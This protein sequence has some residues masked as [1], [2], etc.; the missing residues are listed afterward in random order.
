L[1]GS[2]SFLGPH[3]LYL[4]KFD[5]PVAQ[6]RLAKGFELG[7]NRPDFLRGMV[8]RFVVLPG[9]NFDEISLARFVH[10][11]QYQMRRFRDQAEAAIRGPGLACTLAKSASLPA[12][13]RNVEI[14]VSVPPEGAAGGG[15]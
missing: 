3:D 1:A 4:W 13:T 14:T 12:R 2:G 8:R 6:A 10:A 7:P 11:L 9:E 5:A 15:A